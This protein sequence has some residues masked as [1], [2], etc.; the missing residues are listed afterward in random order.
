MTRKAPKELRRRVEASIA[1]YGSLCAA[2]LQTTEQ[3]DKA[4]FGEKLHKRKAKNKSKKK[5][6]A[7]KAKK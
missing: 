2:P 5:H 7:K 4:Q 6:K 3:L 1:K